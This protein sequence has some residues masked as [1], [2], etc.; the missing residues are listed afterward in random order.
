MVGSVL[1]AVAF[2]AESYIGGLI[3][4]QDKQTLTLIHVPLAMAL[5]GLTV[6]LSAKAVQYRKA[7]LGE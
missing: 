4:D 1:L 5:T 3:R 7:D 6:W 2:L